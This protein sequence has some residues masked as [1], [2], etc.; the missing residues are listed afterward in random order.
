MDLFHLIMEYS[1]VSEDK[2]NVLIDK[3]SNYP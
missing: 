2:F 3:L 1:F